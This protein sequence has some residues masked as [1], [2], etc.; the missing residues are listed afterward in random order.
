MFLESGGGGGKYSYKKVA[1]CSSD[2]HVHNGSRELSSGG[3][4]LP[5]GSFC[6]V[7]SKRKRK[8]KESEKDE[9][10]E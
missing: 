6:F 8:G 9:G 3:V 4:A 7:H 1:S 10:R 5:D 2:G